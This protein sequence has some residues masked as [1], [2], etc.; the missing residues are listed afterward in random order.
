FDYITAARQM[1]QQ[2]DWITPHFYGEARLVKPILFYWILIIA[3]KIFGI[4]IAIARL[5][6]AAASA[7]AVVMIWLTGR[8][9]LG[10]R[11]ALLTAVIAAGHL[12]VVQLSRAAS[13]DTS[14]WAFTS[15]A[16]YAF[17]R[18]ALPVE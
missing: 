2:G 10:K 13:V 18:V 1:V 12:T 7:A 6:S 5:C 14:L 3:F 17:I 16:T 8:H 11:A 9:L 4:H 15:V